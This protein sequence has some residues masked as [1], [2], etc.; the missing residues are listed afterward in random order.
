MGCYPLFAC[1]NWS[2][3]PDDF[4]ELEN[5]LVSLT[6]VTD[7]FGDYSVEGLHTCFP[8]RFLPF[9]KHFVV[10]FDARHTISKHHRY[11][12]QRARAAMHVEAVRDGQAFL[13]HWVELY[14]H[15]S[16]RYG[17]SGIKAFSPSSFAQQLSVPGVVIFRA[18]QANETVGAHIW[19]LQGSIAYSHL[20][21]V[22]ERGY[23]L[24]ASYAL[25]SYA[26]EYFADRVR[27]MD[28]GA[29]AGISSRD[30]EGLARFK[31]G[32]ANQTRTSFLCGRI[33]NGKRY[34]EIRRLCGNG[35]NSYFPAYREGEFT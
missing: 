32:W 17:L 10:E 4:K 20:A 31:Q 35:A 21:A 25:Y 11:Y 19:Y 26:L 8:D 6:L 34:E 16:S 33:F 13:N 1:Q 14:Q 5:D 29:V 24:M 9:K 2:K 30:T 3:L 23:E 27:F 28:L 12:A 7:P 18:E 15:L 22:S